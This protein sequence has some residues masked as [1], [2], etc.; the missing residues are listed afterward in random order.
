MATMPQQFQIFYDGFTKQLGIEDAK[1]IVVYTRDEGPVFYI[2]NSAEVP[3]QVDQATYEQMENNSDLRSTTKMY[4]VTYN[5]KTGER[6]WCWRDSNGKL[7][8]NK[9]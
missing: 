5:E 8:C 7:R 1:L 4:D 3:E 9:K 2:P 6:G